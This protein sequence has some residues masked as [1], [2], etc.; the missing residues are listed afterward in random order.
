MWA[1]SPVVR[2]LAPRR[3]RPLVFPPLAVLAVFWRSLLAP[4]SASVVAGIFAANVVRWFID[5]CHP[6]M[7][8]PVLPPVCGGDRPWWDF[9]HVMTVTSVWIHSGSFFLAFSIL[10]CLLM[11]LWWC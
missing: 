1:L 4:V 10:N 8:Y 7:S 3:R 6:T 11:Y 9:C 5:Q 2:V